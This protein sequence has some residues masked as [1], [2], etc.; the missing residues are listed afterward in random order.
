MRSVFVKYRFFYLYF[1]VMAMYVL[2]Y[3][4]GA[5]LPFANIAFVLATLFVIFDF[6]TLF[7]IKAHIQG[8]RKVHDV[9]SLNDANKVE[10][11]LSNT[12]SRTLSVEVVDELPEQLQKRDYR[13]KT[14]ILPGHTAEHHIFIEPKS[15]G[16]YKFGNLN[17]FVGSMFDL[18]SKRVVLELAQSTEVYPSIISMKRFQ[19]NAESTHTQMFG[20]KK[21]RK[22]GQNYEFDQIKNYV[23]GDDLRTI[24]W[25]NTAKSNKLMV[26]KYDDEKSQ[27]IYSVIDNSRIMNASYRH[28]SLFDFAINTALVISNTVI[29]KYDKAGLLTFSDRVDTFI[30]ASSDK[31]H[32]KK[33]MKG[34]Y[35][36]QERSFEA[37]YEQLYSYVLQN[38][39]QRSLLF[40]YTN[41][42]NSY[43]LDRVLPVLR[44]LN[45]RHLLVVV[46]FT[47]VELEDY[48]QK[49]VTEFKE[50]YDVAL[51]EKM[52]YDKVGIVNQLK[53]HKIQTMLTKPQDLSINTINK[54]LE[55]KARGLI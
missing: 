44:L 52:I 31:A 3:L 14:K 18:F 6:F 22:I 45:R 1:I 9:L 51:A 32:L 38:I 42:D 50:I 29:N 39:K 43:S 21:I 54:Y 16:E 7:R 10:I 53:L 46:F 47:D 13:Y 49:K 37:N 34:L 20:L 12:S 17:I 11:W 26:N 35:N 48:A 40:L 33:I 19:L 28:L 30:K 55:L 4:V 25:K 15:R 27:Q 23:I 36:Q 8:Q 5:L 24:N 41:F 2:A